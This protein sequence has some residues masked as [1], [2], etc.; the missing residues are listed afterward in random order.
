MLAWVRHPSCPGW[1]MTALH[2][3]P[4]LKHYFSP[5]AGVIRRYPFE[6][7]EESPPRD[8]ELP[9]DDKYNFC[10]IQPHL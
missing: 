5:A 2:V 9:T 4:I 1:T 7:L 8:V 10:G 3:L 6:G